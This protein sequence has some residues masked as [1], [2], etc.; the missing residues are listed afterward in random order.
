[1][2][3]IKR[4]IGCCRFLVPIS[5]LMAC[6]LEDLTSTPTPGGATTWYVNGAARV[7]VRACGST[8]CTVIGGADYGDKLVVISTENDTR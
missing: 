5:F 7:N 1:M 4:L 6:G 3:R 8:Q 2:R